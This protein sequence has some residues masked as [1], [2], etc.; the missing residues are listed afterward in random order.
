MN[1]RDEAIQLIKWFMEYEPTK[2]SDYSWIEWPTAKAFANKLIEE[3]INLILLTKDKDFI[4]ENL[5][6]QEAIKWELE[7][8]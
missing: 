7:K 2:L 6:L 5:P 1:P 4:L 8:L 3:R